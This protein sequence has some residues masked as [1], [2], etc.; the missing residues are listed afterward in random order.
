MPRTALENL[1]LSLFQEEKGPLTVPQLREKLA[2][3]EKR[4]NKTTLYRQIQKLLQEGLLTSVTL[5]NDIGYYEYN[6]HH[7]HHVCCESC[8]TILCI[9]DE[10]LEAQIHRLEH[11]LTDQNWQ[12]TRHEFAF[13]GQCPACLS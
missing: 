9:E 2:A 7:H 5:H 10:A 12:I 8:N 13:M 11:Q 4:P 1:V 3:H 6:A